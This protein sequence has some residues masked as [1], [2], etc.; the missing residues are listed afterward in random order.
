MRCDA[1]DNEKISFCVVRAYH[2]VIL[3]HGLVRLSV[4]EV[5]ES[6]KQLPNHRKNNQPEP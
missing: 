6:C 5:Y 2:S 3:E 1:L 4:V